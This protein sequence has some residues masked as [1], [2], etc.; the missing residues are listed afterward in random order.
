MTARD[1]SGNRARFSYCG[2]LL[3]KGTVEGFRRQDRARPWA[4]S[5]STRRRKSPFKSHGPNEECNEE[6]CCFEMDFYPVSECSET[7]SPPV[8]CAVPSSHKRREMIP[9]SSF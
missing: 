1:A 6:G 8:T 9:S 3:S 7:N 5:S 4:Q 2:P